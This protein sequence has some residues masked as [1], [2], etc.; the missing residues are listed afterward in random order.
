L[1]GYEF[2]SRP[3]GLAFRKMTAARPRSPVPSNNRDP[4][5]GAVVRLSKSEAETPVGMVMRLLE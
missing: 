1:D 4:G 3:D 2:E 5:S